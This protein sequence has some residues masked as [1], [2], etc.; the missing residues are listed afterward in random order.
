AY[1]VATPLWQAPDEPGHFEQAALLARWGGPL[2]RHDRDPALEQALLDSLAR[3]RFWTLVR[4]P[5]PEPLPAH[6]ADDPFLARSGRQVGDEPV[7][8]YLPL[9]LLLRLAPDVDG[10][11]RL[12]RAYSL[13]LFALTVAV[14]WAAARELAPEDALLAPAVTA[15]VGLL[16]MA[17]YMGMAVNNDVA[18]ALVGTVHAWALVR[19][20]RRGPRPEALAVLVL[21]G[22]AGLWVKKTAA[23]LLPLTVLVLLTALGRHRQAQGRG[24]VPWR[25]LLRWAAGVTGAALALWLLLRVPGPEPTAW[26]DGALPGFQGRARAAAYEGRYGFQAVDDSPTAVERLVQALPA[27][28]LAGRMAVFTAFAR[29]PEG[30]AVGRLVLI[31]DRGEKCLVAFQVGET[32]QKVEVRCS[33]PQEAQVVKAVLAAGTGEDPAEQGRLYFDSASL[34]AEGS[35]VDLLQ[36]GGAEEAATLGDSLAVRWRRGLQALRLWLGPGALRRLEQ[37]TG[38]C[39][40]LPRALARDRVAWARLAL[41]A[42]L[43]FAGFWGNFGWLT[44]PLSAG[45]YLLLSLATLVAAAG[46][47]RWWVRGAAEPWQRWACAWLA[48]ALLLAALQNLLPM[49][50]RDWQPQGRYL[51]PALF[52]A[53]VSF[54][55]GWRAWVS[56]A[57]ARWG[58]VAF[59]AAFIVLNLVCLVG[60]VI[61]Y[62]HT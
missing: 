11:A 24:G 3:H 31:P 18:A 1:A 60:Y 2:H 45:W 39:V 7:A 21:C 42:V 57:W 43:T 12:A 44:V 14:A 52:P 49:L 8:Y 37:W 41:Y 54:A 6:L 20:A 28:P 15:F 22:P 5:W 17:A 26:L 61:P 47:V 23:F 55:L 30:P 62:F 51:L 36:N 29:S 38:W 33:I 25:A 16:P 40:A 19:L 58:A 27:A 32:W 50:V 48:L 53:A 34:H 13:V 10:Q 35:A 9:A 56:D 46:W 4:A 59:V